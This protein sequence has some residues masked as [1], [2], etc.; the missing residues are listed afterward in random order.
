[1]SGHLQEHTCFAKGVA[2]PLASIK[3]FDSGVTISARVL[4]G[5]S[6]ER[7]TVA[8]L[9]ACTQKQQVSTDSQQLNK[10]Q[11]RLAKLRLRQSAAY[12]R[13]G[14]SALPCNKRSACKSN[15][16]FGISKGKP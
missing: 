2:W 9:L 5:G 11:R 6:D 16:P 7:Q 8:V 15:V 1:M 13:L 14:L 10:S 12:N 4:Q 3:R